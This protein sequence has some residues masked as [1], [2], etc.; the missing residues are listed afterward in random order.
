MH[1]AAVHELQQLN[2]EYKNLQLEKV[3]LVHQ[4][5]TVWFLPWS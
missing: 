4:N 1:E 5:S 2:M 3:Y